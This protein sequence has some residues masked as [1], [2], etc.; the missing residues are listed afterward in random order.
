MTIRS[1]KDNKGSTYEVARMSGVHLATMYDANLIVRAVNAHDKLLA[2][3][4]QHDK[5]A[6]AANFNACGCAY[7]EILAASESQPEVAA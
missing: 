1:G 2:V 7:C 5:E 4:A 6:R 3:K